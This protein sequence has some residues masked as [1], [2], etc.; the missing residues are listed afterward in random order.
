MFLAI[1]TL[2]YSHSTARGEATFTSIP[3]YDASIEWNRTEASTMSFKSPIKLAEADRIRY[4]ATDTRRNFGGQVIKVKA[5]ARDDYEYEVISYLRLY[6]SK[7]TF[8]CKNMTASKIMKKILKKDANQLSTAGITETSIIHGKLKWMNTSIWDIANQLCYL[9]H[10]FGNDI[11]C[12]IDENGTMRFGYSLNN[13]EGYVFT[14][15]LDYSEE[16]DSSDF[17]TQYSVTYNGK[18]VASSSANQSLIAKWGVISEV[19]DC[20][21]SK[22]TSSTSSTKTTTTTTDANAEANIKKWRI[23]SKI[24][25]LAQQIT[26]GKK[27]DKAKAKAIWDWMRNH[28]KYSYYACTRKNALGTLNARAGNCADQTHLYMC[29]AYASGLEVRCNHINGH[30]FPQTKLNGKWFDTDTVTRRGWGGHWGNGG[31]WAYHYDPHKF[32]C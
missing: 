5:T 10:K 1:G 16:Y 31:H 4:E 30:F 28:I 21:T 26:N 27:S 19:E 29:L 13:Q 32:N 15:V 17:V 20:T 23:E 9:E 7:I 14:N 24:V 25:K 22:S 12:H 6:H 2:Y 18:G 8:S 3:F 11:G